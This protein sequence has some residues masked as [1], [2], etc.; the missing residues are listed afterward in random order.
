LT[1]TAG[2]LKPQQC[3]AQR[4]CFGPSCTRIENHETNIQRNYTY[5]KHTVLIGQQQ[6]T[7]SLIRTRYNLQGVLVFLDI[8]LLLYI[9][10]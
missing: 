6:L 10:M 8:L 2:N 3:I 5:S 1:S 7:R 4:V 9:L